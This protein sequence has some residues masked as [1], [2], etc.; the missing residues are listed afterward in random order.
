MKKNTI[1]LLLFITTISFSQEYFEGVLKFKT[2]FQDKKGE[3][4][5]EDSKNFYGNEIT[6]YLKG[7]KYKSVLNGILKLTTYHEGKDTIFV[8]MN[9]S[10]SLMYSLTNV[11]EEKVISYEFK[12]TDV[13][14]LGFKC[15]LLEVK[16]DKGFHQYY[17]NRSLKSHPN[18]YKDHKMGLWN[19][20]SEKTGGAISLKSITDIKDSFNSIELISIDRKELDASIFKRPNL[21]IIKMPE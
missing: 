4:S 15:E 5:D 10:E 7:K 3:L 8:K 9:V 13:V 2:V 6:Y 16:T 14:V 1:I 21:P 17:F 11:E 20:F 19:F 12:K 18:S